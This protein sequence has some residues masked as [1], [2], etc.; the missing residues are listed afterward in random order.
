MEN[1]CLWK[2]MAR[3]SFLLW[4]NHEY[5]YKKA[6]KENY[7]MKEVAYAKQKSKDE[8]KREEKT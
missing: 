1:P 7:C 5:E 8:K 2:L 6:S 4:D 3:A